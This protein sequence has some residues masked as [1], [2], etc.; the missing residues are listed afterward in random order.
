MTWSAPADGG[1]VSSYRI[2]RRL[3]DMGEGGVRVIVSDT[4]SASTSYVDSGAVAGQK[5]IYRVQA[6]NSIGAGQPSKPAQIVVKAAQADTPVPTDTPVPATNTPVPTD[7][8]VP[9]TH[10]PVPTDTPIPPTDTPIPT[11]T[12][13]PG[14]P[15]RAHNLAAAQSDGSVSL[16]WSAPADGGDVNGYRI[17]RRLPDKGDQNLTVLV[18]NTGSAATS[19]VD[20]SA[21]NRQKHIYRVQALGPGGGGQKS[22]PAQ[23]IVRS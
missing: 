5:H 2:W 18:D 23:V 3:P 19:Y 17:W 14:P 7:T 16:T 22:K 8:P 6:L 4:G 11:D 10:T 13:V 9:P 20:G 21:E 1:Q 15:G 12:P